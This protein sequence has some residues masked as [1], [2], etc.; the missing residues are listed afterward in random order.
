M[1][2]VRIVSASVFGPAGICVGPPL[3][4]VSEGT[5]NLVPG[6]EPVKWGVPRKHIKTMTR[7]VQLG[8]AAAGA[9]LEAWPD[10]RSVPP[11]RR[12]MYVGASPQSG[13]PEDLR[14]SLA[15]V[16]EAGGYSLANFAA[17][18]VPLI[19]PLWLVKGLS[20]NILGY[21]AAQWDLQGDNGNWCDGRL[22]GSVAL[23]NAIWAVAEGRVDLALAGGADAL[24]GAE[25]LVGRSA[26]EGAAFLVL[27]PA[28]ETTVEAGLPAEA[29]EPG[30]DERGELGAAQVPVQLARRWLQGEHGFSVGGIRVC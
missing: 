28:E 4:L 11:S 20:N 10:Y 19:P 25:S 18:G 22:S 3:R 7:A 27:V 21:A 12:G 17:V 30:A 13:D 15:A 9:A 29:E 14:P 26:A 24:T 1:R 5:G 16:A 8:F 2:G 23:A 6:F